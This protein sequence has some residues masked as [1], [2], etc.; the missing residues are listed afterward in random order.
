MIIRSQDEGKESVD[1]SRF[2]D[3]QFERYEEI[4]IHH[5]G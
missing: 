2:G 4:Y 1:H 3:W 5:E